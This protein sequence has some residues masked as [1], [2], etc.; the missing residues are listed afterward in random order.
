MSGNILNFPE[1]QKNKKKRRRRNILRRQIRQRRGS[2]RRRR[3]PFLN[4]HSDNN[5]IVEGRHS[6]HRLVVALRISMSIHPRSPSEVG[7]H[8]ITQKDYCKACAQHR[9]KSTH[10]QDS[11]IWIRSNNTHN[12]HSG[13]N[14]H[15]S[16]IY[17]SY[18]CYKH[19]QQ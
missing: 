7:Q 5:V 10:Q 6:Y 8:V 17:E 4:P 9:W 16:I 2:G 3:E 13:G 12:N 1:W 11:K 18:E 19:S 14:K 15:L